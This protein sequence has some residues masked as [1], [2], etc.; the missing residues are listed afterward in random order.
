MKLLYFAWIRTKLGIAE[1]TVFPSDDI[2]DVQELIGWLGSRDDKF[3]AV[4]SD[5]THIK[6]A[7]NQ[8]YV[9]FNH[10]V[11]HGDEVAFFPPV[12]GG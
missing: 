2:S 12:T 6:V 10:P 11:K 5:E 9:D 1:E 8:E 4:F 7:V 3:R